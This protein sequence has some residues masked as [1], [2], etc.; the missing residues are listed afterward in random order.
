MSYK[1]AST[2]KHTFYKNLLNFVIFLHSNISI[3]S[4]FL[5]YKK[6]QNSQTELLALFVVIKQIKHIR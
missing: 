3:K 5:H 1:I 6:K 2:Y 4:Y